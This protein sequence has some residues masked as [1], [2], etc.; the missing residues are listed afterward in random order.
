MAVHPSFVW[1]ELTSADPAASVDFYRAVLGWGHR[2]AGVPG[3]DYTVMSAGPTP[4]AGIMKAMPG[5]PARWVGYVGVPDVDASARRVAELGG[6]V[7]RPPG[8]IPGVGRFAMVA[9]PEGATLTLFKSAGEPPPAPPPDTPGFGGWHELR[10]RDWA[11]VWPFYEAL[12]GWTRQHAVDMGV[13]G[14]YQ[15]FG[16]GAGADAI[17]GMMN[18]PAP[19]DPHWL[20]VF[21]ADAIDEAVTRLRT[22]GGTVTAGPMEVP[23]GSL[24]AHCQDPAGTPFSIVSR[25]RIAS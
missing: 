10:A 3:M 5:M 12:F 18:N 21:N 22:A 2:D 1:Y 17:G 13:H 4:V 15:L 20:Y 7:H 6:T 16:P 24:V 11:A 19:G 23:G 25:A 14:T 9:D 8:D